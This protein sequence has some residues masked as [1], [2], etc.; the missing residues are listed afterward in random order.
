MAAVDFGRATDWPLADRIAELGELARTAGAEVVGQLT[1]RRG[2][3]D[4]AFFIGEGK[5]EKLVSMSVDHD[6]DLIVFDHELS[7]AQARNLEL[8]TGIT[9]IDRTQLILDIFAQRAQTSEGKLQVEL[10]QLQYLLPRLYGKGTALSRLGGGIGTRGPGETKL[11]TDR[12]RVRGRIRDLEQQLNDVRRQR[13]VQRSRRTRQKLPVIALVGYTNAGKSTLL[14][15]LS[16]ADT[17]I[18]DRLFATLDPKT[19]RCRLPGEKT[20]LLTDTVGFINNLPHQ[21]VAAFRAT[22]EEVREADLLL[23]VVDISH[24]R[25]LE[26]VKAVDQVLVGLGVADKPMVVALN[27]AD[28]VDTMPIMPDL[29]AVDQVV[30]SAIS[31]KGIDELKQS[32]ADALTYRRRTL[33]VSIPYGNLDLLDLIHRHGKVHRANYLPDGIEIVAEVESTAA[34][35]IRARLAAVMTT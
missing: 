2:R 8:R 21:L 24:P 7:P 16:G 29:A 33:H 9:V 13:Q 30:T 31:G 10:A 32:L 20:A 12:R 25:A 22:L 14:H 27:K 34:D 26:M 19:R 28:Q 15:V 1:Q 11:E 35:R 3:P 23:H 5:V 18:E 4:P 6:A 17:L